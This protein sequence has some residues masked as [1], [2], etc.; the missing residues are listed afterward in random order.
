MGLGFCFLN[1]KEDTLF[2]DL[3]SSEVIWKGGEESWQW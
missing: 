3:V 2:G 1:V